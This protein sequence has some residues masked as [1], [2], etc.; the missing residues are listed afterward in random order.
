[1]DYLI[2]L[3]FLVALFG[4]AGYRVGVLDYRFMLPRFPKAIAVVSAVLTGLLGFS[5]CCAALGIVVYYAVPAP[6]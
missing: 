1:M 4:Y 5:I 2:S 6:C 3:V